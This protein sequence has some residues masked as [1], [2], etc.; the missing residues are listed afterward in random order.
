MFK[1]SFPKVGVKLNNFPD[2]FK[3]LSQLFLVDYFELKKIRKK[4]NHLVYDA[5]KTIVFQ[6]NNPIHYP[7]KTMGLKPCLFQSSIP[8]TEVRGNG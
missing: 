2:S 4:K 5:P 7:G 3:L 8:L 1:V 6:I